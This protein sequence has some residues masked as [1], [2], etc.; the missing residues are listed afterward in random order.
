MAASGGG[1][2]GVAACRGGGANDIGGGG[3]LA[4]E[5]ISGAGAGAVVAEPAAS[6]RCSSG[7]EGI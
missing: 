2:K 5:N 6:L 4:P 3:T 7:V 1:A